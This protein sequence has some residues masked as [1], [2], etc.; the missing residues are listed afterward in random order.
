[1]GILKKTR[2][3]AENLN[4]AAGAASSLERGLNNVD[5]VS[6]SPVIPA[7]DFAAKSV[8]DTGGVFGDLG[9]KASDGGGGG[10]DGG[11]GGNSGKFLDATYENPESTGSS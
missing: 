1:M 9:F 10:G 11:G 6:L 2:Q 4:A 3:L 7:G 8:K 5:A